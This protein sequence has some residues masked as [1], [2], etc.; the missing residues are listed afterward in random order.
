MPTLVPTGGWSPGPLL[1][2][3]TVNPDQAVFRSDH[4]PPTRASDSWSSGVDIRGG[5]RVPVAN[6]AGDAAKRH[7]GIEQLR[8]L[9]VTQPV[10]VD[11]GR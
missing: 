2:P 4:V 1:E 5:R 8:D 3:G 11:P 6:S 7:A 9:E 10:Q